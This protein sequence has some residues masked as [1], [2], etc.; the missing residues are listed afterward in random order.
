[1]W[2]GRSARGWP[3]LYEPECNG[4]VP[5]EMARGAIGVTM[6]VVIRAAGLADLMG[7]AAAV[8]AAAAAGGVYDGCRLGEDVVLVLGQSAQGT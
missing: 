1:M 7:G 5:E 3:C 6:M 4:I 8:V 2:R